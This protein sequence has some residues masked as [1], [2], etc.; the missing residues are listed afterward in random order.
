MGGGM[1]LS[2]HARAALMNRL[3]NSAGLQTNN[4]YNVPG[5]GSGGAGGMSSSGFHSGSTGKVMPSP[6]SYDQGVLGPASPRPTQCLLIKNM[7]DASEESDPNW[8]HDIEQDVTDECT[9]YGTVSHIHADPQSKG[10]VYL[11]F[12]TLQSAVAAQKALHG[13]WFAGRQIVV[14]FQFLQIYNNHFKC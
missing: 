6:L 7:F 5:A 14:E 8:A 1:K 12:A 4:P 9:K 13:R 3:A 11:K 2:S 10:F